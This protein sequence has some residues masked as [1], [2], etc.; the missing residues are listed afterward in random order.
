MAEHF[1]LSASGSKIWLN[2]PPSYIASQDFP[3][4]G[5]DFAAEHSLDANENV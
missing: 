3:D 5:G 2:C 4:K 1:K